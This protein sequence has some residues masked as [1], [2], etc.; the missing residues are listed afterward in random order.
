MSSK[1]INKPEDKVA[2]GQIVH[3]RILKDPQEVNRHD[4][5]DRPKVYHFAPID[6]EKL[7]VNLTCRSED[8]KCNADADPE[9][10]LDDYFDQKALEVFKRKEKLLKAGVT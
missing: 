6:Y 8:L 2:I 9:C 4:G 5:S 1:K 3:F 7:S 10:D